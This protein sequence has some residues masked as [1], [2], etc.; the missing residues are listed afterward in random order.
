MQGRSPVSARERTA[1][2]LS[3]A[4]R[5]ARAQRSTT[6]MVIDE[7]LGSTGTAGTSVAVSQV[8]HQGRE[9]SCQN[10]QFRTDAEIYRDAADM[11]VRT[12]EITSIQ[13]GGI[14]AALRNLSATYKLPRRW[15]ERLWADE[16]V[17]IYAGCYERLCAALAAAVEAQQ[18]RNAV[19][20]RRLEEMRRRHATREA[21]PEVA[22][23]RGARRVAQT[24]LA[25]A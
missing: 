10:W 17:P 14:V 2:G 11:L 23:Q 21:G 18:A 15:V 3:S 5:G 6:A 12:V 16:K 24:A 20:Q 8:N 13:S 7:K 25:G 9:Q 1:N 4:T 19:D 22:R